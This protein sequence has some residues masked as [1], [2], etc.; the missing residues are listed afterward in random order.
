MYIVYVATNE[1]NGKRYV[2][3]TNN[4][5]RRL[6]EH[7]R[8]PYPFGRALRKYGKEAFCFDQIEV[9]DYQHALD[10]EGLMIGPEEVKDDMYYNVLI[11]GLLGNVIK[12]D[13]PMHD[14]NVVAKHPSLFTST[15][16]PMFN[17]KSKQ[18]MIESQ[19]RRSVVIEGQTYEGV[20]EA[21]RKLNVSR[22]C[23][24]HRLKSDNFPE[25]SYVID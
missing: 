11:G 2:G 9:P 21:A 12:G 1:T 25:Y 18:K 4:F 19:K 16:N 24:V 22:Q 5:R 6:T 10:L 8:S 15:D 13:N 7:L 17:P 14:P 20:R 3:V 23:L